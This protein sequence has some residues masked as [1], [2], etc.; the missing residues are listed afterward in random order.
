[1]EAAREWGRT[2]ASYLS[3]TY[4][5]LAF[6]LA[7]EAAVVGLWFADAEVFGELSALLLDAHTLFLVPVVVFP[8]IG[9]ISGSFF[10]SLNPMAA[11]VFIIAGACVEKA[12]WVGILIIFLG[13]WPIYVRQEAAITQV[14]LGMALALIEFI[15]YRSSRKLFIVVALVTC[16]IAILCG[17]IRGKQVHTYLAN[18]AYVVFDTLFRLLGQTSTGFYATI[19]CA[20]ITQYI[21]MMLKDRENRRSKKTQ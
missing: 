4:S 12:V 2:V 19:A 16:I 18:L 14:V 1:M 11:I 7:M 20:F 9:S 8:L 6:V 13:V 5:G 15:A 10:A 3:V 17:F 21:A